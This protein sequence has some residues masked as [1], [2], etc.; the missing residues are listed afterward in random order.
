MPTEWEKGKGSGPEAGGKHQILLRQRE[1][2]QISGVVEMIAFDD[3]TV[4]ADTRMGMLSIKGEDLHVKRV[5]LETEE[6]EVEG[7]VSQLVYQGASQK[8][9]KGEA[10]MKRL[11]R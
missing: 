7:R 6:L 10:W 11:V 3:K 2:C 8:G 1:W 5:S 9:K 4:T